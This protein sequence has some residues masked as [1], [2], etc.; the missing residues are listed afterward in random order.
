[1]SDRG[2]MA[3]FEATLGDMFRRMG[4]P[5]PGVSAK[6][7]DDWDGVTGEPWA[8]RSKPLVI[9]GTTLVVEASTPSQVAFLKYA[10]ADLL[11]TL[12][13]L[14]GKGII[15]RIEVRPPPR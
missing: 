1:M 12:E 4:L 11:E 10:V 14:V 3:S 8:G 6:V 7:F 9:Q 5:E 15:E 13:T 2:D